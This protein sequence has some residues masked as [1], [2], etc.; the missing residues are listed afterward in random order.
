MWYKEKRLQN[1]QY[2][3]TCYSSLNGKEVIIKKILWITND[4]K[5]GD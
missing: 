1:K 3:E 5:S 2:L 4:R